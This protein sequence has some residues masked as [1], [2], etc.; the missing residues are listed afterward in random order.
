MSHHV[1]QSDYQQ[2]DAKIGCQH[3]N[4][5][6]IQIFPLPEKCDKGQRPQGELDQLEIFRRIPHRVLIAKAETVEHVQ[7]PKAAYHAVHHIISPAVIRYDE[8]VQAY[9]QKKEHPQSGGKYG[10]SRQSHK[11]G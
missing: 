4:G 2:D 8:A 11:V 10:A 6:V 7:Q 9:R 5:L 1:R 3:T